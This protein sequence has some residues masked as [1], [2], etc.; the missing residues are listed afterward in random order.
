M[1]VLNLIY[2]KQNYNSNQNF[3]LST[4]LGIS[5]EQTYIEE[6]EGL[7]EIFRKLGI[8]LRRK[9]EHTSYNRV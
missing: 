5:G 3:G 7:L 1:G 9:G 4:S 8:K 2:A 6:E